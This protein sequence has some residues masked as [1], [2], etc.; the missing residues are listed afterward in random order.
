MF[1]RR[2][3]WADVKR[4]IARSDAMQSW[5]DARLRESA[6][7]LRWDAKGGAA[8]SRLVA[9]AYALVREASRRET[10]RPHYPVQIFG[11]LV[12]FHGAIAEMQTGEGKTLTATLPAFLRALPGRGCHVMTSNEYLAARDAELNA[13]LYQRLGLKVGCLRTGMDD[14]QRRIEYASDITYGT[15]KEFGFDFLRDRLKL[16]EAGDETDRQRPFGTSADPARQ[17]VQRGHEFALVDEADSVL[18]DEART[19]LIIGLQVPQEPSTVGLLRW[20]RTIAEWML[21]DQHFV[22]DSRARAAYLTDQ[23]C[24]EIVLLPKPGVLDGVDSDAIYDHVERAVTANVAFRLNRDYVVRKD[25]AF[26][27]DEGTGRLME[28]RK[29]QAG[30]HQAVEAKEFLPISPGTSQ[31]AR[32]TVQSYFRRYRHVAGMTGTAQNAKREL[33]RTYGLNVMTVPTHRKNLRKGLPYRLFVTEAAKNRAILDEILRVS[34]LGRSILIGTPSVEAS[35]SLSAL[36]QEAGIEHEILNA[37][38]HER[39]ATIV[40]E[41]GQPGRVTIATN[42]AGRGTDIELSKAVKQNGGLH[43]IAT[44][45]HSSSRIDRQLIGRAARQGDPGSYQFFLSL[46]DELVHILSPSERI[47]LKA[48]ARGSADGTLTKDWIRFFRRLQKRLETQYESERGE[49]LKSEEARHTR[50]RE[51]GLNPYLELTE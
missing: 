11:G 26:I 42:M 44:E 29:W 15:V 24:R 16:G 7:R 4:I 1:L 13:S 37:K 43:V 2:K 32:V 34:K 3:L 31:A 48:E 35:E 40:A 38:N 9:E 12:M 14:N 49:L 41:A 10:G 8:L 23:G 17:P 46:D 39:E 45:L 36:L 30:L 19:P 6:V 51:M 50:H 47:K 20:S 22:Y 5:T 33:K 18:I 25:E 28:G 21:P 27:V